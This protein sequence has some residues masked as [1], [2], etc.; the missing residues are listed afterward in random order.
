MAQVTGLVQKVT[1][2]PGG[3]TGDSWCCVW[4]GA[5]PTNTALLSVI[6]KGTDSVQSGSFTGAMVEALVSAQVNRREVVL[7]HGDNDSLVTSVTVNP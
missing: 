6:Q 1:I 2:V 7:V 4:V 3:G 5:S